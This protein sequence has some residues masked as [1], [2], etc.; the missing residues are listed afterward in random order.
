MPK[1]IRRKFN[2]VERITMNAGSGGTA[3]VYNFSCNSMFDPN[4]TGVGHQPLGFDQLMTM[5]DHF[6]VTRAELSAT[7]LSPSPTTSLGQQICSIGISDV[8]ESPANIETILERGNVKFGLLGGQEGSGSQ[9]TLHHSVDVGKFL[10]RKSPLS[11]PDLKGSAS[12][13]PA[14]ECY[15]QLAVAAPGTGDPNTLDVLVSV[16]YTGYLIEPK[17]PIGS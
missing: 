6:V 17:R 16:V 7:F 1:M 12:A 5:Y 3:G 4:R 14:E 9:V 11:D 10:G 13:N 15:F 8:I 2:Y